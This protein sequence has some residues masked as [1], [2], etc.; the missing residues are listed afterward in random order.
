M[1]LWQ[2]ADVPLHKDLKPDRILVPGETVKLQ[3]LPE[4]ALLLVKGST[5]AFNTL[6]IKE[7][8]AHIALGPSSLS[9][10]ISA[11][12]GPIGGTHGLSI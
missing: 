1:L 10:D 8:S 12:L 6:L 5:D 3:D 4:R 9:T 11:S 2:R 7:R